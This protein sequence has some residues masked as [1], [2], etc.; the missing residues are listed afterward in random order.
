MPATVESASRS[1][2]LTRTEALDTV[3]LAAKLLY[4]NGQTSERVVLAV[5]RLG[6]TLGLP[7]TLHLSWS[8]L[9][10]QVEGMPFSEMVGAMPLGVDMGK[11]LGVMRVI[12]QVCE[13]KLPLEDARCALEVA[14]FHYSP[15]STSRFALFAALGA[16]ALGVIFGATEAVS[17]LLMAFSAGLGALFRRWLAKVSE[18]PFIQPLSAALLAGVVA[19]A[20]ERLRLSGAASSLTALC[21]CMIL[22]P[23]PHILNGAIDMARARVAIGLARLTYAGLLI[24]AINIGLLVGLEACGAALPPA[25][26]SLV[27]PFTADVTAAGCAAAAF[28]TFFSIPWRLLPLPIA[29]GMLAHGVRWAAISFAGADVAT[30]AFA[31]CLFVGLVVAPVADRLH[32]PFAA[33]GFSAVVSMMPGFFLFH[34]ASDLSELVSIGSRAPVDLLIGIVSNGATAFLIILAMTFGL[35]LPRMLLGRFLPPASRRL[36]TQVKTEMPSFIQGAD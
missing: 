7:L 27:V 32:L 28:G 20:A 19:A 36:P 34:A 4:K 2:G 11:V 3:A 15:A 29:V 25:A 21:P 10:L 24:L 9:A 17:L 35:I 13:G 18:N 16:A 30:G 31:A 6:H 26:S 33:L 5:E 8:E 14:A 23:G 12:D 1:P 22:V